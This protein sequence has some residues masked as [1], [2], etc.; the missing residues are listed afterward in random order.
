MSK[1]ILLSGVKPT[2]R[3]HIGNYFGA[4][5]QF[6]DLQDEYE[7]YIFIADLHAL[8][9]LHDPKELASNVIDVATDY[10]AIG[11]DPEKVILFKQSDVP[12]VTELSWIFNTLTT[13]P[14]LERA[15]AYKD[16]MAKGREVNVGTFDYPILMAADILIQDADMVPV[17]QDQKQHVEYARDTAE[18]FNRTYG[19]IFKLPEVLIEKNVAVVPGTDGEKMS[20]SHDNTIPLFADPDKI[21]KIVMSIVTDSVS[22]IPKNVYA[23]HRL[24]KDEKSL[25][26]LY[27]EN[28]GKYKILKEALFNDIVDFVS[29]LGARRAELAAKPEKLLEVLKIGGSKARE[30]AARKMESVRKLVGLSIYS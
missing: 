27:E 13:M 2:G 17:G 23:I 4:M 8:T 21:Q 25:T 3:P 20:K 12:E 11:L 5:K 14:Y 29:P 30:R 6:V 22:D 28:R 24:F 15:H 16:A 10:L 7:C 18:K 1:K 9:T 26:A 19:K